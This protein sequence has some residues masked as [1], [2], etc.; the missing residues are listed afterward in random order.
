MINKASL[1]T[2]LVF[3][4]LLPLSALAAKPV[5]HSGFIEGR[6]KLDKCPKRHGSYCYIKPGINLAN[7]SKI[8]FTPIEF[9]LHMHSPYSGVQPDDFKLVSDMFHRTLMGQL[10]PDYPVVHSTDARTLA[11]RIALIDIKLK[12]RSRT[13]MGWT[14]IGLVAGTAQDRVSKKLKL[15]DA[16]LEAEFLDGATGERLAVLVDQ[17]LYEDGSNTESWDAM[18]LV[19]KYYAQRI[20]L[21]LDEAHGKK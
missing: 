15:Q 7:Y 3:S 9:R 17:N 16:V 12:K 10:E 11:V 1:I 5:T 2:V 14:P 18:Q 8:A 19:F 20:K 21:R 13:L 4:L 6:V